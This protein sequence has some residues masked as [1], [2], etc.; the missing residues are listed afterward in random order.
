MHIRNHPAGYGLVTK[1]LHWTTLA[2]LAA[3]F[4]VGYA[5]TRADDVLEPLVDRWLGGQDDRLLGVH[6]A[7]GI[8]V[9]A[10]ATVRLGWRVATPLP[11]WAEGLSPVERR[12]EH[13]AERALYAALLL[14]PLTGLALV[15]ASGEDWELGG[16]EWTAPFEIADDDALLGAHIATHLAFFAALAV[17][18]G[19]VLKHQLIDRDRLLARML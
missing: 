3:Q 4:V 8:A 9:L 13:V 16:T 11:E 14:I 18:V 6:V 12:V 10:L 2:A 7:L 19:L 17:H 1:V 5:L 15:L